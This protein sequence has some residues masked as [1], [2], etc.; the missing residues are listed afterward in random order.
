MLGVM[1]LSRKSLGFVF[2]LLAL[3]SFIACGKKEAAPS[4]AT[5][6]TKQQTVAAPA[7]PTASPDEPPAPSRTIALPTGLGRRTGDLDDM[8]KHRSIRALVLLSP[9]GFF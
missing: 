8:V 5:E 3:I 9:I 1:T 6:Q 7:P 2:L 4:A